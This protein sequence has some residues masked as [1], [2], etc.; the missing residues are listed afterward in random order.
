MVEFVFNKIA[1]IDFHQEAFP[2]NTV[3][4]SGLSHN[5]QTYTKLVHRLFSEIFLR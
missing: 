1:R 2:V 5:G 4:F 3:E